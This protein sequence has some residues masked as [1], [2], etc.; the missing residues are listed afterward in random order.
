MHSE[1]PRLTAAN[2]G[3]HSSCEALFTQLLKK[4]TA[5]RF[6]CLGTVDGKNFVFVTDGEERSAQRS[7]AMTS[8]L[9]ALAESFS[10]EAL[11]SRCMHVTLSTEMGAIVVVRVPSKTNAFAL[12]IGADSTDVLAAT[13]RHAL[14]TAEVLGTLIDR[15]LDAARTKSTGPKTGPVTRGDIIPANPKEK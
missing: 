11:K 7:S 3:L 12:S 8:S 15:H 5:V 9:L 6:A 13:L 1:M 10:R 2:Q 14:D 4:A